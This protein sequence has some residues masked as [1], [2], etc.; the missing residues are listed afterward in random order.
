[1]PVSLPSLV[2][3]Y[4]VTRLPPFYRLLIYPVANLNVKKGL[5]LDLIILAT[6]NIQS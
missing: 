4:S 2:S 1:M 3:N 5:D 6:I